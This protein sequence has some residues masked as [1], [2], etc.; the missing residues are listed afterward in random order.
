MTDVLYAGPLRRERPPAPQPPSSG[1]T[2]SGLPPC[3]V[4]GRAVR[5]DGINY[6]PPP[7]TAGSA[8]I[9]QQGDAA[10]LVAPLSAIAPG[11]AIG[12]EGPI[13]E[14]YLYSTVVK[15][16]AG[17][18]YLLQPP[19][20]YVPAGGKLYLQRAVI[21]RSLLNLGAGAVIVDD[22]PGTGPAG[23][24]GPA[25]PAGSQGP[26]GTPGAPGATGATGPPGAAGPAGPQ[27][28]AGTGINFKGSVA[29][30]GDLPAT[31]NA[32]GD[33]YTDLSSGDLYVW[34][35]TA[36]VNAGPFQ[37]P[38]GP[39][40]PAGAAGATGPAGPSGAQGPTGA[41]GPGGAT[42]PQGPPGLPSAAGAGNN[43]F[44]PGTV[45]L[46]GLPPQSGYLNANPSFISN[47]AYWRVASGPG[48]ITQATANA[49]CPGL[50][51]ATLAQGTPGT[52]TP[53][54]Q[55][56]YAPVLV[57]VLEGFPYQFGAWVQAPVAGNVTL[58]LAFL[59]DSQAIIGATVNATFAVAAGTWTWVTTTQVAPSGAGSVIFAVSAA[60]TMYPLNLTL[61][62][63]A[64][65][66]PPA[67]VRSYFALAT[68]TTTVTNDNVSRPDST[69]LVTVVLSRPC[70]VTVTGTVQG[71]VTTANTIVNGYLVMRLHADAADQAVGYSLIAQNSG[72]AQGA[73]ITGTWSFPGL[74][75]GSHTFQLAYAWNGTASAA[76]MANGTVTALVTP[77]PT[78]PSN[79]V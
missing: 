49:G 15:L 35:G 17:A 54:A 65:G 62:G 53:Q 42:G 24:P 40:G 69:T 48:T 79:P 43:V 59:D 47:T 16:T 11:T 23:P 21:D 20:V 58:A 45:L 25:G 30:P 8:L 6:D 50:T 27:G 67:R 60:A 1:Y 70:D 12:D 10:V 77:T 13:N 74:A 3:D 75:A 2:P 64:E 31:G 66:T 33:A 63:I 18:T 38:A 46:G 4:P 19:G 37:G 32:D 9:Q 73:T 68:V 71:R 44:G 72:I 22:G 28:A 78:Y 29:T 14:A 55:A 34:N 57:P 52:G 56:G 39:T 5:A 76:T 61:A 41:Q 51:M 26:A 7:E 36:W